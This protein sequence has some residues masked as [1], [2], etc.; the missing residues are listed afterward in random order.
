MDH[1]WKVM[2]HCNRQT[3]KQKTPPNNSNSNK[4]TRG[5]SSSLQ[6]G[7]AQYNVTLSLITSIPLAT[8]YHSVTWGYRAVFL[9]YHLTLVPRPQDR[10]L[11]LL[12][13]LL[14]SRDPS[15]ASGQSGLQGIPQCSGKQ[16]DWKHFHS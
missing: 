15:A 12:S 14:A 1:T 8:S 5:G 6:V 16:Y 3:N 9:P 4:N 2:G 13:S 11:S 7:M 10:Q